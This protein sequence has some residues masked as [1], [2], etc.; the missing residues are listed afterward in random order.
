MYRWWITELY[1]EIYIILLTNVT[2]I[3]SIKNNISDRICKNILGAAVL[4]RRSVEMKEGDSCFTI[5]F[6]PSSH[7]THSKIYLRITCRNSERE[8]WRKHG[9]MLIFKMRWW[10]AHGNGFTI[11]AAFLRVWNDFKTKTFKMNTFNF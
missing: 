2:P 3:N 6:E 11:S 7:V 8:W 9:K 4:K 5:Y 1:T 10:R